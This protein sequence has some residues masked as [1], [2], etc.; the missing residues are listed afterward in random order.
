MNGLRVSRL[1]PRHQNSKTTGLQ[2]QK[3]EAQS[4]YKGIYETPSRI[5]THVILLFSYPN[6]S[7]PHN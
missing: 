3:F 2:P 6:F 7:S 1:H 4:D 5:G